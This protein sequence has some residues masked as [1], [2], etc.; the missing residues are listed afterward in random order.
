[1]EIEEKV[2]PIVIEEVTEAATDENDPRA[3]IYAKHREQ[4]EAEQAGTLIGTSPVAAEP[5]EPTEPAPSPEPDE[6]VT[7]KINGKE[8]QVSKAKIDE[9][10]GLDI[11][12]K[13]HAAEENMRHAAE[14][15][16]RVQEF[17]QQLVA[18]AQDL[19]RLEQEIKQRATQQ[20]ATPPPP[21]QDEVK[22]MARQ[23]HEAMLNGDMDQADELLIKLQGARQATP[24]VDAI[25]K[26]A[27]AEAKAAMV[28]E[29]KQEKAR[30]F[31]EARIEAVQVFE[32][33]YAD[34]ADDPELRDWA[35]LKT[36]KIA[37]ENPKWSPAQII[38]EAARQVREAIGKKESKADTSTADK[39]D[40]KRS[41]THIKAGNARSVPKAPPRPPTK[42][43]YVENLRKQR[44]LE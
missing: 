42:S 17:E 30:E 37:R 34:V 23:Y 2:E 3:A 44:G 11:Y 4:R 19:Q 26:R 14:E 5:A 39:L 41:I 31:E 20:P 7:V 32:A 24:D 1:M 35:D 29:R 25:A 15:R 40:A 10:G 33:D 43:Q 8:K 16:R 13:R 12:Q 28:N 27:A 18:K 6:M 9:A 22:Q 38:E 36:L 21:N